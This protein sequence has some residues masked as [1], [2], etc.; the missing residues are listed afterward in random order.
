MYLGPLIFE[1]PILYY[2]VKL[3]ECFLGMA[4]DKSKKKKVLKPASADFAKALDALR[5]E[6]QELASIQRATE[7]VLSGIRYELLLYLVGSPV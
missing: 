1:Y 7:K 6:Q 2:I 5:L 3:S 4:P